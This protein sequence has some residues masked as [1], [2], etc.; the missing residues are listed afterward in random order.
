[1]VAIVSQGGVEVGTD[2]GPLLLN[3]KTGVQIAETDFTRPPRTA[4]RG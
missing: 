1:M 4:V 2:S 3:T